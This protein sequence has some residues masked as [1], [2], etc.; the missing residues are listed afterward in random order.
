VRESDFEEEEDHYYCQSRGVSSHETRRADAL[1]QSGALPRTRFGP[2][3]TLAD[4][5]VYFRCSALISKSKG[6]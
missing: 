1:T 6:G 5:T 4:V 2:G 3:R